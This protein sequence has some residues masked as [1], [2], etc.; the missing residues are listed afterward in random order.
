MS[1]HSGHRPPKDPTAAVAELAALDAHIRLLVGQSEQA[2][3]AWAHFESQLA[4]ARLHRDVLMRRLNATPATPAVQVA[5]GA[6]VGSEPAHAPAGPVRG[7]TGPLGPVGSL[8]AAG[9]GRPE[10]STKTVQNVLF[11]LGG[12]L[13]GTAAVVFTAVAWAA[14]GVG[15]RATILAALTVLVLATPVLAVRRGLTATAETF[16]AVGLLLVVL[17]GYAAWYVDLF[18]VANRS[19]AQYAGLVALL[20]AVVAAGYGAATRLVGPGFVAIL[21]IQPVVAL[22]AVP[23]RPDAAGWSVIATAVAGLNL[24]VI[25]V[26]RGGRGATGRR[27]AAWTFYGIALAVAAI[28][29]AGA[30]ALVRDA[31]T[32]ALAGL[33]VVAVAGVV[34]AAAAVSRQDVLRSLAATFCVL[35]VS[36]AA[37]VYVGVLR[38]SL[39]LV[40]VAAVVSGVAVLALAAGRAIAG[41]A[42]GPV[43]ADPIAG[44]PAATGPAS[45]GTAGRAVRSGTLAGAGITLGTLALALLG[46]TLAGAL[47]TVARALP[48][49]HS[50]LA[51]TPAFTWQLLAAIG[52]TAA[53]LWWVLGRS[54]RP[55]V[56]AV[57]AVLVVLALPN[58]VELTWWAP[59]IVD[60]LA[61]AVLL[62]AAILPRPVTSTVGPA[63]AGAVLALHAVGAG[64][65]R[66]AGTAVVLAG[67]VAI[68]LAAGSLS[69]V[70]GA[71][72]A[73]AGGSL[74][75]GLV[76]FP[77]AVA[78]AQ[79]AAGWAGTLELTPVW[80]GR[81]TLAAVA[82]G[83]AGLF[84]VHR[85]RSGLAGY[86]FAATVVSAAIWPV[87]VVLADGEPAGVYGAVSLLLIA[88]AT[89]PVLSTSDS[90]VPATGVRPASMAVAITAA[91]PGAVLLAVGVL[92]AVLAVIGGPFTWFGAIWSG[93]PT[94]VGL[95]P[96]GTTG[97]PAVTAVATWSLALLALASATAT[98][99]VT[100]RIPAALAGLG[101][102]GPTAVIVGC[103]AAGLP[104]PVVPAVT[105]LLGLGL[106][107]VAAIAPLG[108]V[109]T[110]VA[111][112]QALAYLGAGL[113]GTLTVRWSTIVGLASIV[114][115]AAV[116]GTVG[117]GATWRVCGWLGSVVAAL[118]LAVAAGRAADLAVRDTAPGVL[119][120]AIGALALSAALRPRR[121]AESRDVAGRDDP[122][123]RDV[124]GRD[125]PESRDVA[126]RDDPES[127]AVAAAA[128]AGAVVALLLTTGWIGHAALVS[129]VW[130][131]A[132][133][134]R[135]IWPG[136]GR[137]ARAA[138]AATGAGWDLLA[139]WLLLGDRGVGLVE[140]YTLPLAAV[141]LLAGWAALRARPDLRSWVSYGPALAAL[142]LP[143]LALVLSGADSP[144]RRLLLGLAALLVVLAGAVRRRQA[145]VV[146]GGLVLVVVALH[147]IGLVW[148][149]L[150]RWIPLALG[151]L[152]LVGLAITYERRLRDAARLRD[153]LRRMS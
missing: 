67:L 61:A 66:P 122:E 110:V 31:A 151:G 6:P 35:A 12:L 131:V 128:H 126:G 16:A 148:D 70:A 54:S 102:G 147:E 28:N 15:G 10:S 18:G 48:P 50:A 135:A 55:T 49:W 59:S 3:Q 22:L 92:P 104:W 63:V 109:R 116:V 136:T 112:A 117:R 152:L 94:G 38:P 124:A 153:A 80:T 89:I 145:P 73:V 36:L 56:L 26:R 82:L 99:A 14:Y 88:V 30:E 20:T 74:A 132:V 149:L 51:T 97:L 83:L 9:P 37:G 39:A 96:A 11:I 34:A 107:A 108:P 72:R 140:A 46:F 105:L 23:L 42:G 129:A 93:A 41:R 141:G 60:L 114:V 125:D 25:A 52:L 27:T 79:I 111:T 65:G 127:T 68:A 119:A 71:S 47:R 100:R 101:I 53:A 32:A 115:I 95:V 69:R 150:P 120:V 45:Q 5:P 19:G 8:P 118:G 81:L 64:L 17:D 144:W 24:L 40:A 98:Y 78:S 87:V 85:W 13:L 1:E 139:W 4:A 77:P 134:L 76:A 133:G 43:T 29:A 7:T 91:G 113:A 57:A 62:A 137:P 142:L 106:L 84:A 58:S 146:A 123:S 121:R 21:A 75:V 2:R 90:S 143:S 130:G 44:D 103:V 138:L 86:A 33:A